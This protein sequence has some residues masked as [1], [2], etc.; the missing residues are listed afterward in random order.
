VEAQET[1]EQ[2]EQAHHQKNKRAALLIIGLAAALAI[3]E[4]AGKEAQFASIAHNIESSD[5]W[6]FYQAKTIRSTMVHT[7]AEAA[8][9]LPDDGIPAEGAAAR[10]KQLDAWKSASDRLDSNPATQDGRK[11]LA[12]RAKQIEVTRDEEIRA[13]HDYEYSSAA[14]QLAIVMASASVIT[15]LTFL[16]IVSGVLGAAG[17]ALAA[18]GWL[19]PALIKL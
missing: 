15:E 11:E 12:E 17:V 4:M 1:H 14:L 2:V 7:A 13:Y 5:L 18:V 8:T 9:L 19:A 16:E 10:Q 6:A 3:A